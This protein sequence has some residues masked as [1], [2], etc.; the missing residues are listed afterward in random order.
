MYEF[1]YK[2]I[3]TPF[4]YVMRYIY[5]F[6]GNYALS[7]FLFALLVKVLMIP[8]TIKQKK[9]M[10]EQQRIQ[11]MIQKIQKT[12]ARDQRR[13]QEEMQNLYDREGISPM[14][15]CGTMLLTFPILIGLY[16]VIIQPLTYFMQVN[17]DQIAEIARILSYDT[18]SA[19]YH[20]QIELA[21]IIYEHFDKVAHVAESLMRVDFSLGPISMAAKPEFSQPG[22]LW[23]LPIVSAATS[24]L[25]SWMTQKMNPMQNANAQAQSTNK[26]MMLMMPLMSL[27]FGFILPVGLSFYWICNNVLAIVQELFMNIWTK[28]QMEKMNNNK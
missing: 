17:A 6:V 13:M 27:W 9:S 10:L 8:M 26:T 20:F 1:L 24:Y 11:P 14:A 7:L 15:G 25:M 5:E 12:Y 2:L 28:K 19:G 18:A 23:L 4:G 3:S 16:G 22:I 21:S